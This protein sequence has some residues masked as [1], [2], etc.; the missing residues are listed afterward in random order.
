M[1]EIDPRILLTGPPFDILPLR[2]KVRPRDVTEDIRNRKAIRELEPVALLRLLADL[3]QAKTMP[4][5]GGQLEFGP[6]F[7]LRHPLPIGYGAM[8]TIPFR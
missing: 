2:T 6:T 3:A 4:M 5:M 7:N 1:A 8:L